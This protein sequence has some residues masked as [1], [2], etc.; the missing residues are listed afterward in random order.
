MGA[1]AAAESYIL[2]LRQRER[3]SGAEMRQ[4][5]GWWDGGQRRAQGGRKGEDRDK[6]RAVT[7]FL[8]QD[9]PS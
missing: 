8:Q 4:D 2:I 7:H 9:Q 6:H 1:G 5:G 3:E